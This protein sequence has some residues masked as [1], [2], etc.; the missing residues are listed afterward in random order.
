MQSAT[1]IFFDKIFFRSSLIT[2]ETPDCELL[3]LMLIVFFV[4]KFS[5][6]KNDDR[7]VSV[8]EKLIQSNSYQNDL[9]LVSDFFISEMLSLMNP[10]KNNY[11][12]FNLPNGR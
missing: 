5:I 8:F 11:I 10:Y 7:L 3:N 9:D 12:V 2:L 6:A 1:G 4:R